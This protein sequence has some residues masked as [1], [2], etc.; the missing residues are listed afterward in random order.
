MHICSLLCGSL[1]VHGC[2]QLIIDFV[3]EREQKMA[4]ALCSSSVSRK[5][6]NI[7]P[8]M[9]GSQTPWRIARPTNL[10]GEAAAAADAASPQSQLRLQSRIHPTGERGRGRCR[11]ANIGDGRQRATLAL[12]ALFKLLRR[13]ERNFI[14]CITL[15]SP[16]PFTPFPFHPFFVPPPP[17]PP[18]CCSSMQLSRCSGGVPRFT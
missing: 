15:P 17:P 9:P 12:F 5:C 3:F 18:R 16:S 13:E 1:N 11:D 8:A 10:K 4:S 6:N 2:Q 7:V 14:D